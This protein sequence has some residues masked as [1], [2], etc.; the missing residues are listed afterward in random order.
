MSAA[1]HDS[2]EWARRPERSN[3]LMLR[4]MS[5]I[6]LR[7]GRPAGRIVLHL[8]AAYFMLFA[9]ASR[10]ASRAYLSRVLARP[11]RWPDIYRHFFRFAATVH[12]RVYLLNGRF[13]LFDIETHGLTELNDAADDGK[14]VVLIG[15]H[16]GS[17]ESVRALGRQQPGA[18]VAMA[19]Y[20]ENARKINQALA[21]INPSASQGIIALGKM[22]SM[23]LV[24]EYIEKGTL[25]GMLADRTLGG[26][27][28]RSL[29]F[30]GGMAN[31]AR[32]P[33]RVAAIMRRPVFF[34]TGLYLGGNRYAI[35][36][37]KLADFSQMSSGQREAAVD[38]AMARYVGLLERY[39]RLEPYNWFN[40]F[41]FWQ[42]AALG[43]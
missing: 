2:A 14:G 35:H 17:F 24:R 6:S 20:E 38:E 4:I 39:C 41:D 13:D 1:D 26:D 11:A 23:L 10:K 3:M 25:V 15:A 16:L 40:F 32:G 30:L 7:L 18:R 22:D 43:T 9:P 37:E 31:F 21:A 8:I 42:D 27:G 36:F 12:D 29:P 34:M 28:M 19:M 5:W 33:F